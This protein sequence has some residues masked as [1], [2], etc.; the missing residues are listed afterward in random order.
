MKCVPV[1]FTAICLAR[2]AVNPILPKNVPAILAVA[3]LTNLPTPVCA[4]SPASDTF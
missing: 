4:F 3:L 1:P 2:F